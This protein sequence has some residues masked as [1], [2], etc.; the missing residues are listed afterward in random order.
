VGYQI[1]RIEL[2]SELEAVSATII[3][4]RMRSAEG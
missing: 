1:E 2:D 3:R 4:E